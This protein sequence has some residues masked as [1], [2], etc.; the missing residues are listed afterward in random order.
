MGRDSCQNATIIE[1]AKHKNCVR[2]LTSCKGVLESPSLTPA[3]VKSQ[4]GPGENPAR[5][6]PNHRKGTDN[7]K[8]RDMTD[9]SMG[10]FHPVHVKKELTNDCWKISATIGNDK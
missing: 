7:A 4:T 1:Q 6:I 3:Q 2:D 9:V 5:P 8:H 10:Q